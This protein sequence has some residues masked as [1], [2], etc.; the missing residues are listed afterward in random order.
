MAFVSKKKKNKGELQL[1]ANQNNRFLH[2]VCS[3]KKKK[4]KK[5]CRLRFILVAFTIFL[6]SRDLSSKAG[7]K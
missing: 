1:Q 4:R 3:K 6:S 2:L 5:I 7:K